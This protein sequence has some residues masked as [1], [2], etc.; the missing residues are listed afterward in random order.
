MAQV[1]PVLR[2]RA[3]AWTTVPV[4]SAAGLTELTALVATLTN[5]PGVSATP[6]ERDL[7]AGV[8]SWGTSATLEHNKRRAALRRIAELTTIP[9]YTHPDWF[10]RTTGGQAVVGPPDLL[11][12]PNALL[13]KM[14]AEVLSHVSGAS[15]L[16]GGSLP[17]VDLD[18]MV[19]AKMWAPV[20]QVDAVFPALPIYWSPGQVYGSGNASTPVPTLYVPT[21]TEVGQVA[22][23]ASRYAAS[24]T[25]GKA[26]AA[27]QVFPF[28]AWWGVGDGGGRGAPPTT[29]ARMATAFTAWMNAVDAAPGTYGTAPLLVV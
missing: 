25:E 18:A 16:P 22:E 12:A 10:G 8:N 13:L 9:A 2:W 4:P 17:W 7:A 5:R 14:L 1:T 11:H 21:N 20:L 29:A 23:I 15:G 3:Q 6:L 24:S 26:F 19:T 27:Q 28:L